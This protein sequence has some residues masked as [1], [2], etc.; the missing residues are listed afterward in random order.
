MLQCCTAVWPTDPVL[1]SNLLIDLP[2]D[3]GGPRRRGTFSIM[4]EAQTHQSAYCCFKVGLLQ[5]AWRKFGKA[6]RGDRFGGVQDEP[7]P[8]QKTLCGQ[9]TPDGGQY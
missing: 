6:L 3:V 5:L 4:V 8:R 2:E 1:F 9:S 7:G